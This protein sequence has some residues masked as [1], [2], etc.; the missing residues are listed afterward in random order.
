MKGYLQRIA[1]TAVRPRGNIHPF[2]GSM[3]PTARREPAIDAA[4]QIEELIVADAGQ[5]AGTRRDASGATNDAARRHDPASADAHPT[6]TR[7]TERV[8]F[9]PL[10]PDARR[11]TATPAIHANADER[12][13]DSQPVFLY[14]KQPETKPSER[15]LAER[16]V[17]EDAPSSGSNVEL[18]RSLRQTLRESEGSLSVNRARRITPSYASQP[19]SPA[20]EPDEIQIHIG[21]IEVTAMPPPVARPVAPAAR[22]GPSLDEYLSRRDG[23]A[24]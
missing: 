12:E 21:R 5:R 13:R 20:R 18:T 24:R 6:V 22:K 19:A 17:F 2:V 1:A 15:E 14:A 3:F 16:I 8:S 10:L 23:R 7:S 4:P 11:E 9:Q